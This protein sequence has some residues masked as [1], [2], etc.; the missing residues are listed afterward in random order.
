MAFVFPAFDEP[1]VIGPRLTWTA[2]LESY[3]QRND[4]VYYVVT[5]RRDDGDAVR[6]VVQVSLHWAGDDWT[7]P[8]FV[9]RLRREI[10]TVASTGRTNTTYPGYG[11][12]SS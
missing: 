2:V 1:V 7:G 6:F 11:R 4:D 10:H 3:D 5:L 12:S 8:G 9:E